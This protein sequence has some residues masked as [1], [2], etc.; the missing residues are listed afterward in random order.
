MPSQ[1]AFVCPHCDELTS[2]DV[3]G[4]AESGNPENV[5]PAEF[6]L[7][8]CG[9]LDC[10]MPIV[11]VR[12]DYG[13]GFHADTPTLYF[14][15]PRRLSWSIPED[16]RDAFLEVVK[17]FQAKAYLAAV[18]IVRRLLEG[19]CQLQ[20]SK[21]R[22]LIDALEE[23]REKGVIDQRLSEWAHLLRTVGNAGAHFSTQEVTRDDAKDSMDFAEALLDHIYVLSSRFDDFKSRQTP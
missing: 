6:A 4:T 9:N 23:L 19:T 20:G 14:P 17:C 8:Q 22:R 13:P 7:L 21:K 18:V 3:L 12:E 2:S 1:R 15:S 5:P 16:L 11:Q 10:E